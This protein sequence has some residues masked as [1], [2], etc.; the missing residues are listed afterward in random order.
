[1]NKDMLLSQIQISLQ[2][3]KKE[4][5]DFFIFIKTQ[6][7][8]TIEET[9]NKSY[10]LLLYAHWEGFIKETSIKYF[11]FICSQKR[12]VKDLTNNFYLIYFKDILKNYQISRAISIEKEILTKTL[13]K[14]KKF[15]IEIDKEHF[16]KYV[17]G[18]EDNL[19]FNNYKNICEILDYVLE[20][21]TGKFNIILEKL[22]HNRNSIAHTGIKADE[23]TYTDIADIEDMKNAIIKE[24]DNFYL[25]VE[26]NIKNDRYLI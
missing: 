26:S 8:E 19:K 11:S 12:Q 9:I 13:D 17:L 4:L 23:N 14:N 25:F 7:S 6:Q 2:N 15:K 3:R 5:L 18:I 22:V 10:I 16:Q 20:D 24:M 1:M 21:L